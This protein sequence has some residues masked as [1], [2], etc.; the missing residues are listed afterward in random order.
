MLTGEDIFNATLALSVVG[1]VAYEKRFNPDQVGEIIKAAGVT[2][3]ALFETT[4][5][6]RALLDDI[7]EHIEEESNV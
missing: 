5:K 6:F 3:D 1:C 2:E 4:T 7:Q